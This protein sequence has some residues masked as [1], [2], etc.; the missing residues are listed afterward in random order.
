MAEYM[1]N[2]TKILKYDLVH[3]CG[4][5]EELGTP[6][7]ACLAAAVCRSHL[8]FSVGLLLLTLTQIAVRHFV[9]GF[10]F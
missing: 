1:L 8:R 3:V 5:N 7:R 2:Y 10:L 9:R 4:L 6:S